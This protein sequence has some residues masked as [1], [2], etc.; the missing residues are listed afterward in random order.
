MLS[1]YRRK[2]YVLGGGQE[3]GLSCLGIMGIG[4]TSGVTL[5]GC[6]SFLEISMFARDALTSWWRCASVAVVL[7]WACQLIVPL[8]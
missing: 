4:P 2:G 6:M 5:K 8:K 1:W 3:Q 7:S